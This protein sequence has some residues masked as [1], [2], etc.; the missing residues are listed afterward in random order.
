MIILL[1][2]Q[3]VTFYTLIYSKMTHIDLDCFN[4]EQRPTELCYDC[5]EFGQYLMD[6]WK[7]DLSDQL[8]EQWRDEQVE[9][10]SEKLEFIS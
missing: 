7:I 1:S 9:M 8:Y 6:T 10:E 5:L 3:W 2:S 4:D